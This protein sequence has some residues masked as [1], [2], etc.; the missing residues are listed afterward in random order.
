[1][2]RKATL[3]DLERYQ[4]IWAEA[5]GD[6]A[7]FS[8]M[9][10]E[11]FAGPGNVYVEETEGRVAAILSA[12]PCTLKGRKGFYF[13]GLATEKS[14]QGKG[15][16]KSLMAFAENA[17]HTEGA[18]FVC[19]IPASESL[20]SFYEK[21]GWQRAFALRSL[22]RPIKRNLWAQAEFDSC[23]AGQLLELRKQYSPDSVLLD[24]NRMIQVLTNLYSGGITV[25]S[26]KDGYALYFEKDGVLDVIEIF[27]EGER[28]AEKLLEAA[29]EKVGAETARITVG[30]GSV[31]FLGEGKPQD[32]GMIKF[33]GQPFDIFECYMRL[34]LDN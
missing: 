19:L 31:L 20:F 23:T 5:F 6:P 34:M 22:T 17:L 30:T 15:L 12:V 1:M 27:A 33:L 3:Q 16:M 18:E 2:A 32:Y 4:L 11:K 21:Q 29:R 26:N 9:V 28:A 8:K 14:Q 24:K 25:V 10:F 7:E 13:Y